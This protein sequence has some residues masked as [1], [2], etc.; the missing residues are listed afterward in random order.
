[1]EIIFL[2][3]DSVGVV[4]R[5]TDHE[6]VCSGWAECSLLP[7]DTCLV[8]YDRSGNSPKEETQPTEV[9]QS[10][11]T[12]KSPGESHASCR[13][14]VFGVIGAAQLNFVHPCDSDAELQ[15]CN[16]RYLHAEM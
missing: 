16:A 5:L 11:I 2:T 13:G 9:I 12:E 7:Y 4:D 14:P 8:V 6:S 10:I 1:M 15:Q 3:N